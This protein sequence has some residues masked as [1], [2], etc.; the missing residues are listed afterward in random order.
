M[1][2]G[3]DT[4]SKPPQP[5]SPARSDKSSDSEGRQVRENLKETTLDTLPPSDKTQAVQD[6]MTDAPNGTDV[7]VDTNTSESESS[8]GRLRRKRSRE[9]FEDET[10]KPQEKKVL[11]HH[12][13]K[14]SRDVTSPKDSDVDSQAASKSPIPRIPEQEGLE[15]AAKPQQPSADRPQTP[16]AV[17]T[18][19]AATMLS[20]KNKRPLDQTRSGDAPSASIS[21]SGASVAGEERDPKRPRDTDHVSEPAKET[22]T[23][24]PPGSGFANTSAASPFSSLSATPK[25]STSKVDSKN[26][27]LGQPQ[28]SDDK[29]KASGFGSFA[30]SSAS[31]FGG[32]TQTASASPFGGAA[33]G[34]KLTSFASPAPTSNAPAS[35]FSALGSKT[36]TSGFGGSTAPT[37]GGSGF[38]GALGSSAFGGLGGPSSGLKSFATPGAQTITGLKQKNVR[39][40]GAQAD[41]EEEDDEEDDDSRDEE[42]AT[43]N[44]TDKVKHP[45]S[46][47]LKNFQPMDVETGEEGEEPRWIGRAKL[48][49]MDGEGDARAWHERG[50]GP[51]KLNITKEEPTR[52]R[53]VLRADG[54]HRLL[55][56]AAVTKT[57]TFGDA[58]GSKPSDGRLLFNTP[59]ADGTL[60]MHLL[61]MKA[62]RA[63]ELW[64]T[65]EDV[66]KI[67]P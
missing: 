67:L 4:A 21:I 19:N 62:E 51:F 9:D 26:G 6:P 11:E 45:E 22:Q 44:D 16:E 53:F 18:T 36:G 8:R 33:G 29:F 55:L 7:A 50:V 66:K 13:R 65:V 61:R 40:F 24:I 3:E 43:N 64:E 42:A 35:S 27:T 2:R 25:D 38:G 49:T 17:D 56:N 41:D 54:T 20:P 37:L 60:E 14:K 5:T 57:T 28:T 52:A 58:A 46:K 32:V 31:P 23:K 59:T 30:S 63:F 1:D 10:D 12:A 15:E 39:P 48:Y 47:P 34:S